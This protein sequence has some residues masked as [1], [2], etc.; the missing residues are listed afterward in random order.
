MDDPTNHLDLESITALN[1]GLIDYKGSILFASH[2]HQ[3]IQTIANRLI[4]IT[5]NGI[6]DRADTTYDEFRNNKQVESQIAELEK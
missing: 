4:Y 5:E 1:D 6:V 3:F 2:D